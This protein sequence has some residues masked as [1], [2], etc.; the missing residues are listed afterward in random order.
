LFEIYGTSIPPDATFTLRI[1]D[2]VVKGYPYNGTIAPPYTT[3]YGLYDR[4]YSFDKK[5]PFDL[6]KQ[7]QNPPSDFILE[8][9][10]NF[11][12]TNDIIGGNSGSPVINEKAQ[13][14]GLA[15]D[16][17]I[18]SLPGNF[19]FTTETNRTVA[20][21]SAGMM[22]AIKDLYKAARLSE[23]LKTGSAVSGK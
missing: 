16:G 15:F 18:E 22:E 9:P 20:V 10:M 19:I 17:N 4:Y 21:H 11:V 12:S 7:W 2:G 3:F 8:T 23:E 5:Y 1:S 14:V 6:P 13:I